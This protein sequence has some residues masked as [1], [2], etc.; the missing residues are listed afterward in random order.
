VSPGRRAGAGR[1]TSCATGPMACRATRCAYRA[2]SPS[3]RKP[4]L[5]RGV[6]VSVFDLQSAIN[7]FVQEHKNEPKSF[8]WTAGSDTIIAAVK[9]G[10][11]ALD[12]IRY[13]LSFQPRFFSSAI[14]LLISSS[15][16]FSRMISRTTLSI[17]HVASTASP[18]SLNS[19]IP[20]P[21]GS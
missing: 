1:S 6:F 7:Q 20:V 8:V 15:G 13:V 5:K 11:Q 18:N 12:L 14:P 17:L 9:R 2:A 4:I 16:S 10:H 21:I 3:D 19:T